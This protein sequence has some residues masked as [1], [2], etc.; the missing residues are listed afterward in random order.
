MTMSS[1]N[2]SLLRAA[3]EVGE[4]KTVSSVT[5]NLQHSDGTTEQVTYSNCKCLDTRLSAINT[6]DSVNKY[7]RFRPG[8][9]T[10]EN[11][12][13]TFQLPRGGGYTDPRG[14]DENGVSV[15]AYKLGDF[16]GYNH[17]APNIGYLGDQITTINFGSNSGGEVT[18]VECVFY[19]GEVDWFGDE[20]SYWGSNNLP[21]YTQILAIDAD[22][23]SVL[24][25]VEKDDLETIGSTKRAI[26]QLQLSAPSSTNG[27]KE[28]NV[29]FG[30]GYY[31][32]AY[33]YFDGIIKT[34]K[35]VIDNEPRYLIQITPD[36][37]DELKEAMNGYDSADETNDILTVE[38]T[39][40][41]GAITAG[42][43]T[44][45][46][47]NVGFKILMYNTLNSYSITQLRWAISGYIEEFNVNTQTV[48]STNTFSTT[49]AAS[50]YETYSFNMTLPATA[51]DGYVYRVYLTGFGNTLVVKNE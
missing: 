47:T 25:I 36:Y 44:V 40:Q 14:T 4:T 33:A 49:L 51:K 42:N 32:K 6:S 35:L 21:L 3:C 17:S 45:G 48:T 26:F 43:T 13:L 8:Y 24:G 50:G 31:N 19:L 7:S 38:I 34:Y 37:Y 11:S 16:R 29:K 41:S 30:L 46:A 23:S 28:Y 18:S 39:N 5:V 12:I 9:W 27:T 20:G 15:E 1:T 10:V 2:I 22:T